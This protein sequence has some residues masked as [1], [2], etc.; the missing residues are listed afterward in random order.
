M[1]HL[2]Y[3]VETPDKA[4]LL[5][6]AS[7]DSP[8]CS[9]EVTSYSRTTDKDSDTFDF[10]YYRNDYSPLTVDFLQLEYDGQPVILFSFKETLQAKVYL[11]PTNPSKHI[12]RIPVD[13]PLF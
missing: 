11:H 4:T 2:F 7:G 13:P 10:E 8:L 3:P 12:L 5:G 1:D 9:W 6:F